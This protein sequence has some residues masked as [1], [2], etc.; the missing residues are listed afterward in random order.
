M[1]PITGAA[2]LA[3]VIGWPVAHSLS[4]RLHGYWLHHHN[5]DGA[6]VPLAV[7][8]NNLEVAVRGLS[9]MGFAGANVTVPH[10]EA[11]MAL[12]DGLSE[13]AQR[14]GAVNTIVCRDDG[15]LFGDNTDAF[16]FFSNLS[17]GAPSWMPNRGPALVLGAGG[18][19]RAVIAAL[20]DARVPEIRVV[21]RT[22]ARAEALA[23][24]FGTSV[25]A[26]PW[27]ARGEAAGDVGLLV[28]TTSLG[29]TGKDP[30]DMPIS[31]C[32]D[33][34]IVTDIVYSP[35]ETPLL[36]AATDRGLAS[37]DGLGMLLH[38]ARPGFDAWFGRLP[39]VT[40]DLRAHMMVALADA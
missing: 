13:T 10:K 24:E 7:A 11:V 36:S 1:H 21:N 14:I 40:P 39:D 12:M 22:A 4:P 15:S 26:M 17:A 2:T 25:V 27:A 20:M 23:E 8:P 33:D 19:A 34:C 6:Y 16:G 30:L 28:N 35:L 9:A 5:I 38:Q 3:G 29:M 37:V 32:P 18:A 31:Q